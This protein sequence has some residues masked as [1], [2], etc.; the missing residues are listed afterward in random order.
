[1]AWLGAA[2]LV[3]TAVPVARVLCSAQVRAYRCAGLADCCVRA[4]G[5]RVHPA[6]PVLA[7]FARPALGY[8]VGVANASAWAAVI[9]CAVV[10]RLVVP[11]AWLVLAL[12][13]SVSLGMVLGALWGG[14]CCGGLGCPV[15]GWHDRCGSAWRPPCWRAASAQPARSCWLR[16]AL[17]QRR[18]VP[19]PRLGLCPSVHSDA[20]TSC[21]LPAGPDVG[22]ATATRRQRWARHEDR[23]A[24]DRQYRG[25]RA[26]RSKHRPTAG[27]ARPPDTGVLSESHGRGPGVQR[28]WS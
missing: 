26:A 16:S 10:L 5:C 15:L 3:A 13:A 9:I 24:I 28:A 20:A 6:W 4:G 14:C 22:V 12:A 11:A 21:T 19:A 18:S 2:L 7:Y 25:H 17:W 1:M 8:G 23:S 27:A